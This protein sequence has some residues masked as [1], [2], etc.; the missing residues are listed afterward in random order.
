MQGLKTRIKAF[1]QKLIKSAFFK[2]LFNLFFPKKTTMENFSEKY[3]FWKP[4]QTRVFSAQTG[5][6]FHQLVCAPHT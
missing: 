5:V 3:F 6:C 2:S 4:L 1:L